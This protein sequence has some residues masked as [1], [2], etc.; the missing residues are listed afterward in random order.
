MSEVFNL[1]RLKKN[2]LKDNDEIT[3][4]L[5]H[6]RSILKS[7]SCDLIAELIDSR[8]DGIFT[9]C[10]RSTLFQL[11]QIP[12]TVNANFINETVYLA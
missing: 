7:F 4:I 3:L 8:I 5:E 2:V 10:A 11:L 1:D 12:T 6:I 9:D